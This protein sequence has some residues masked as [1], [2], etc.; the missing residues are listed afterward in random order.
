M[1]AAL[2]SDAVQELLVELRQQ[3]QPVPH[4]LLSL[5]KERADGPVAFL[6]CQLPGPLEL[7]A[8]AW[9]GVGLLLASEVG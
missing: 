6:M 3:P 5:A 8:F 2:P 1:A 9:A 4:A 7:A